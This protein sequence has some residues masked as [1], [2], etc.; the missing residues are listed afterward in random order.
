MVMLIGHDLSKDF[1]HFLLVSVIHACNWPAIGL[2]FALG[3]DIVYEQVKLKLFDQ[4][5]I[6]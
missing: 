5:A 1:L 6:N 2:S 4:T 3:L